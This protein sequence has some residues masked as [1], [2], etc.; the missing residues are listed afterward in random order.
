[1]GG[2]KLVFKA[3]REA[4]ESIRRDG[5][6][7]ENVG[8]LVGA[9]GGAKWLVLSQL[10]RVIAESLLPRLS[11]PVHLVG[12]SIGAWRFACYAQDDP[13]AAIG[14]FED[15]Y[16]GQSYSDK[17][18]IHEITARSR[19]ILQT[20][21]GESGTRE[22]LDHPV[23]RTHILAVRA[24]NLAAF[25]ARPLLGAA[26]AVAAS[27]N[28]I[29]R[30]LL[31]VFF[32]RALFFDARDLPPFFDVGGFPLQRIR[33]GVDNLEDAI[34]ATGSIPLV[35]TGVRDIERAMPGV[36]RD[37]G[38]IDYHVDIPHTEPGRIALFP[39]FY[40]H[41]V[42]GW[43]DKRLSWRKPEPGNISRTVLVSPSDEFVASLPHGKIPDRFDFQRYQPAERVGIWRRVVTACAALADEFHDVIERGELGARL[44]PLD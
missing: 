1:M 21:L 41:I 23:L 43:F 34:V 22:V 24:R 39:H 4:L 3:G 19:E 38:I 35:L 36:Y 7:P 11:G 13:V 27:L 31:A 33:I 40:G 30:R 29:D 16:I 26:L 8:T 20:V 37:G 44:E 42:P 32:E 5:F 12:T 9:S 18:D 6:A 2:H 25:D 15:A 14:R 28:A 17:P 10:D